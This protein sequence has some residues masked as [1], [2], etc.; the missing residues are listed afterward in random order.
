MQR[1][2]TGSAGLVGST[3]ISHLSIR[4]KNCALRSP[5]STNDSKKVLLQCPTR[6]AEYIK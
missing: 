2:V 1:L 6:L 3:V 4:V 5:Q